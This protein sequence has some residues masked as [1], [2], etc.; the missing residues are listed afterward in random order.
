MVRRLFFKAIAVEELAPSAVGLF[1]REIVTSKERHGVVLVNC[2]TLSDRYFEQLTYT[3]LHIGV[4][5][6]ETR[7]CS[8]PRLNF[9]IAANIQDEF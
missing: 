7:H 8:A 5:S 4:A 2:A 3:Y 6:P 9:F 1:R